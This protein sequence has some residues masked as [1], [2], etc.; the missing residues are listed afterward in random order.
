MREWRDQSIDKGS[1]LSGKRRG[2]TSEICGKQAEGS[3][4]DIHECKK[5]THTRG[6]FAPS[7]RS[8]CEVIWERG[9]TH[10]P[11]GHELAVGLVEG[12]TDV[13]CQSQGTPGCK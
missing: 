9:E 12:I 10:C 1:S 2:R 3:S 4:W 11:S 13:V 8:S 6:G 7:P 5:V